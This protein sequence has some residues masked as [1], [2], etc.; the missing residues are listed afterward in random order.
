MSEVADPEEGSSSGSRVGGNEEQS[1]VDAMDTS[2]SN[3]I[4][5]TEQNPDEVVEDS[6]TVGSSESEA[7]LSERA[8]ASTALESP[9]VGSPRVQFENIKEEEI[10]YPMFGDSVD[11][12]EDRKN[13][14][15]H[16]YEHK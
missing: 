4:P 8:S 14:R 5:V 13:H 3:T 11:L 12:E 2:S 9:K 10:S 6:E 16:K 1:E 7:P 15:H